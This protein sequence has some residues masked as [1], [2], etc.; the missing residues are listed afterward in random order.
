MTAWAQ[1][2]VALMGWTIEAP[3]L[4]D[5]LVR[6]RPPGIIIGAGW[7]QNGPKRSVTCAVVVGT[8][9]QFRQEFAS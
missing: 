7:Y 9:Q 5:V 3:T 1:F 4:T 8:T 6:F 2:L